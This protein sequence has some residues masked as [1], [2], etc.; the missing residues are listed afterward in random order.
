MG[1]ADEWDAGCDP[2]RGHGDVEH[3]VRFLHMRLGVR[4]MDTFTHYDPVDQLVAVV[5]GR[6][7]FV[8]IHPY[9]REALGQAANDTRASVA[10]NLSLAATDPAWLITT[11]PDINGGVWARQHALM[12]GDVLCIPRSW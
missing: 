6:K 8:I 9:M 2:V 11:Y 10:C 12:P 4:S 7:R 1:A 3:S 5:R